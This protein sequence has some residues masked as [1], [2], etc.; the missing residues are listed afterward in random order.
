MIDWFHGLVCYCSSWESP[1]KHIL[2]PIIFQI[3]FPFSL[4]RKPFHL[5]SP[6][7]CSLLIVVFFCMCVFLLFLQILFMNKIDL[8]QDKILHSG[9]HLRLYLPQFKGRTDV[10]SIRRD[11]IL[12]DW[13]LNCYIGNK[14]KK[15]ESVTVRIM[16]LQSKFLHK[17]RNCL[18]IL[19]QN[20]GQNIAGKYSKIKH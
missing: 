19:V 3:D 1:N 16:F 14:D 8:F 7:H 10:G 17:H 20:D 5:W 6:S 13:K 15:Y 4:E 12:S 18:G 2:F 9:R 11:F